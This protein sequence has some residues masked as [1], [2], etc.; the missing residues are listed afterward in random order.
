M[1]YALTAAIAGAVLGMLG[2]MKIFPAII[3]TAYGMMYAIPDILLP[4]DF[5]LI[6]GT[7]ASAVLLTAETV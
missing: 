6:A 3:I 2:G 4:Y 5:F 7:T 1:F